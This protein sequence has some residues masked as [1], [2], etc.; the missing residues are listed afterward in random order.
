MVAK[1]LFRTLHT[2]N[3]TNG[4][5]PEVNIPA[6]A[7]PATPCEQKLVEYEE[8]LAHLSQQKELHTLAL[9]EMYQFLCKLDS[10]FKE[11]NQ[12]LRDLIEIEQARSAKLIEVTKGLWDIIELMDDGNPRPI[13]LTAELSKEMEELQLLDVEV[14]DESK[15]TLSKKDKFPHIDEIA[16]MMAA[17]G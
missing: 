9:K 3:G 4:S 7:R 11:E 5:Y 10:S 2:M 16:P 8:Q 13:A 17:V 15:A 14:S 12:K 6:A 1:N